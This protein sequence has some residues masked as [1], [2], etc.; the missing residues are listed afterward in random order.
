MNWL[1]HRI[2][3]CHPSADACSKSWKAYTSL[4][5]PLHE[6][7]SSTKRREQDVSATIVLLFGPCR[8]PAIL[9]FVIAVIV[10]I[11]I[12]RLSRRTLAH[13]FKEILKRQPA[14]TY[15]N[16]PSAVMPVAI[17]KWIGAAREHM[18]PR[19]INRGAS[20]SVFYALSLHAVPFDKSKWLPLDMST[21]GL[22]ACRNIGRLATAAFAKFG[23]ML[24]SHVITP[25]MVLVRSLV[26]VCASPGFAILARAPT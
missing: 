22:V 15:R 1:C 8:P 13:I 2:F 23:R 12:K 17:V 3:V 18:L 14:S 6:R 10:W 16:S 19:A 9:R 26:D 24:V 5:R 21:L 20:H 11:T 7:L 4:S 25:I